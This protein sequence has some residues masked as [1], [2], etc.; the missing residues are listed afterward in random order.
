[1]PPHLFPEILHSILQFLADDKESLSSSSLV[2]RT[3]V[4]FARTYL[5]PKDTFLTINPSNVGLY[6]L[7]ESPHCTVIQHIHRLIATVGTQEQF[8]RLWD[9]LRRGLTLEDLTIS[10]HQFEPTAAVD[11][12]ITTDPP[13]LTSLELAVTNFYLTRSSFRIRELA[14]LVRIINS[15]SRLEQLSFGDCSTALVPFS[16]S[17]PRLLLASLQCLT[18]WNRSFPTFL[19]WLTHTGFD[20]CPKLKRLRIYWSIRGD[21]D[22]REGRRLL[23]EFLDGACADHIEAIEFMALDQRSTIWADINLQNLRRLTHVQ[24]NYTVKMRLAEDDVEGAIA[25]A[26]TASTAGK[27]VT[28][29][30]FGPDQDI[31]SSRVPKDSSRMEWLWFAC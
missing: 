2:C 10:W 30:I 11:T 3:W 19:P 1:M 20:G 15:C 17:L 27:H 31:W 25:V 7:L 29:V 14:W 12:P 6:A 18:L 28:V 9:V 16:P 13:S 23:Q 22:S 4:P 21:T 24:V 5:I 26:S 8:G